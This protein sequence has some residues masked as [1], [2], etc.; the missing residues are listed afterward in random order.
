M[1]GVSGGSGHTSEAGGAGFFLSAA[2][3]VVR[4]APTV[5]TTVNARPRA[6]RRLIRSSTSEG[7]AADAQRARAGG[8][9]S[10]QPGAGAVR[11]MTTRAA[12]RPRRLRRIAPPVN[13]M[14][15]RRMPGGQRF[16]ERDVRRCR[17][18]SIEPV[19]LRTGEE[20]AHVGG[21]TAAG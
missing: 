15:D 21:G 16:V 20:R 19:D 4:S 1:R 2:V 17:D 3:S 12:Q 6:A 10:Q 8:A 7:V 18:Q 11:V 13:R 5:I 9:E 14:S